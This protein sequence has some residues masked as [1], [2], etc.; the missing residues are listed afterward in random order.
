[1]LFMKKVLG[2]LAFCLYCAGVVS[3]QGR[4]ASL[5]SHMQIRAGLNY[6]N[7]TIS[8]NGSVD[9][10]NTLNSFHAGV[11]VDLPLAKVLSFQGGLFY[12]GKGSKVE[13][14]KPG[15]AVYVKGTSGPMY[16]ELPIQLVGKIPLGFTK[17]LL[18]AGPYAAIGITGKNKLEIQS[19]GTTTYSNKD[20]QFSGDSA[21]T[22][23]IYGFGKLKRLDY[24]LNL[25]AGIE[26]SRFVLTANYGMGMTDIK[27]GNSNNDNDKNKYRVFALS[28]GL[29]L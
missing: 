18:G 3:G 21:T 25:L 27:E 5:E 2:A 6:S 17:I 1:M 29:K 9:N 7:I 4:S 20:I 16:I 11:L 19:G 10:A 15:D 14:G 26:F 28:F 24:G 8:D 23:S 22:P 12:T 13:F